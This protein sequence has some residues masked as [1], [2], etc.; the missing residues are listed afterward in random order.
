LER[1]LYSQQPLA[2]DKSYVFVSSHFHFKI[3]NAVGMLQNQ[4]NGPQWHAVLECSRDGLV[5]C[6][7]RYFDTQAIA[8][9]GEII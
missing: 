7:L 9:G 5:L 3:Q 6:N 4:R 1:R 2:E 8:L